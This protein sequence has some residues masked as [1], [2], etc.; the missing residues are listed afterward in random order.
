MFRSVIHGKYSIETAKLKILKPKSSHLIEINAKQTSLTT[1]HIE[2]K[3][4]EHALQ[5]L[6]PLKISEII[7]F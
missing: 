1:N 3:Y 5:H 2:R 7:F 4:S 6:E